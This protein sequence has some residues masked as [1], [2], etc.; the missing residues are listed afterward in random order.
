MSAQPFV[1][2]VV[3]FPARGVGGDPSYRGNWSPNFVE[4]MLATYHKFGTGAVVDPME[5]GGTTRAVCKKLGIQYYGADLK[6][7]FDACNHSLKERVDARAGRDV[8]IGTIAW[9][10]P[11]AGQIIYNANDPRDLSAHGTDMRAFR[12]MAGAC[13]ANFAAAL[14][15]G[16]TLCV[17]IGTWRKN[18][19]VYRLSTIIEEAASE[20]GLVC[21]DEVIK[22]QHN[23]RSS[24][25]SY[26]GNFVPLAHETL[27]VFRKPTVVQSQAEVA[28]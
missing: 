2:S 7:G 22:M 14:A 20:A 19:V 3:S 1:S 5:G 11:Y 10:P 13:A 27:L 25:K 21:I 15:P 23:V 28:A 17:L 4:A 18:G 9:H 12:I 8:R 26:G 24:S 6:T 16:G